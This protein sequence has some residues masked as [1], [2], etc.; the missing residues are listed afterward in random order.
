MGEIRII[1][2]PE[3]TT[4][5]SDDVVLVDS[6]TGGVKKM[7]AQNIGNYFSVMNVST[8]EYSQ[9]TPSQKSNGNA[10]VITDAETPTIFLYGNPYVYEEE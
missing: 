8:Y 10:Y 7:S 5:A 4:V 9:L 1:D 2:L 3:A 6:S